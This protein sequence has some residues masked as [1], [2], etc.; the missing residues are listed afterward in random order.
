MPPGETEPLWLHTNQI[1]G[2]DH[3]GVQVVSIALYSE[4]LPGLTNVTDRV[5][6]YSFYP[7]VLHRYAKDIR[8]ASYKTWY[9][10]LRRADFLLALVA[11]THHL[12]GQE[13]AEAVVG[14]ETA[15]TA[16]GQLRRAPSAQK[17]ISTWSFLWQEGKKKPYFK[18][19][20]GG[21]G[22]YYKATLAELGLIDLTDEAPGVRLV[23]GHGTTLAESCDS[24]DGRDKFW[25]AIVTNRI[26]FD[27]IKG[28]GKSLCPCALASFA[29]ERDFLRQLLF[30][31]AGGTDQ[32]A[33]RR[34]NSL[35]LLLT[36]LNQSSDDTNP[37]ESYRQTAYYGQNA[38]GRRFAIP[39][40][41]EKTVSRWAI[42]QAGEYV[43]RAL[44]EILLAVLM[45]L[46]VEAMA[47]EGFA[48]DFARDALSFS[49]HDLGLGTRKKPWAS[50]SL[51][52]L[53]AEAGAGQKVD[54]NWTTGLWSENCLIA[55]AAKAT[56]Q[57]RKTAFGLGCILSVLARAVF[58]AE[59]YAAF[60][61]LGSDFR[62]RHAVNLASITRFI[63]DRQAESAATVL[64][65]MLREKVL[66]QHL[67]VAMRKL[68]YQTQATFK[69]VVDLG[70]YVWVEDF[71]PTFTSP[72]LR[73][74][75]YFLRDIGLAKGKAGGWGLTGDGKALLRQPNGP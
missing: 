62:D 20:E 18:N 57:R 15:V 4:L 7:W 31:G 14:S 51:A 63:R 49:S 66:F 38:T 73:P 61:T 35:R 41:L 71:E 3:L 16:I 74:S 6:Y 5:R 54:G 72:R 10:H 22:Q 50:Y 64:A 45:R 53:I 13:G 23:R 17:P 70:H 48:D 32:Q 19:K 11:K 68:R 34:S 1:T 8:R 12:D 42:Y 26:S 21:F 60:E 75:F 52:D 30:G 28:L 43:N 47:V 2:R 65:A 40:A 59:P 46:Q 39:A 56:D 37:W 58:P 33:R 25:Q 36:F 44:E 9:E 55:R 24:Q 29:E 69:L 67:R 27:E